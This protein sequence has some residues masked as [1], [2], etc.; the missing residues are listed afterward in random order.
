MKDVLLFV[1]WAFAIGV[2]LREMWEYVNRH[3]TNDPFVSAR[4]LWRRSIGA[5]CLGLSMTLFYFYDPIMARADSAW[6]GVTLFATMIALVVFSVYLALRDAR[7]AAEVALGEQARL[8][9]SSIAALRASAVNS[10]EG[11]EGQ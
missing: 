2:T 5:W 7:I 6:L 9:Q 1:T 11:N 3:T 10:E 4:R 8:A